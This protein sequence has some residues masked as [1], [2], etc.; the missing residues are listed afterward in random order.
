MNKNHSSLKLAVLALSVLTMIWGYNWVVMKEALRY[1]SPFDFAALRTLLGAVSLF[2]VL[3]WQGKSLRPQ[4]FWWMLLLGL[5]QTT[6]FIGMTIWALENGGAGKSAVLAYIMPFWVLILAWPILGERI[7]GA[8]WAAVIMAFSGLVLVLEPWALGGSFFSKVLAVLAGVCWGV[9]A[10]VVKIMRER[11]EYDL[12]LLTAW[13]MLLGAIPLVMIALTFPA[14]PV[15]WSS[16]FIGAL[17]YNAL[18]GTAIGWLLWLY[19]LHKLPAGTASLGTLATPVVG[20]MAAWVQLG[21]KPGVSEGWGMILIGA[22][23]FLLVMLGIHQHKRVNPE[24][25]QE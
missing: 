7:R 14:Q 17:L 6:G 13:Q 9:S 12:I 1:S 25:A 20:V 5:L 15:Q 10:I 18:F 16:Y 23:L 19:S 2:L 4:G 24:M 11:A 21:E 8:Q 22:G 3:L